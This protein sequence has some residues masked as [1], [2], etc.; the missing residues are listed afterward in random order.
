MAVIASP[1]SGSNTTPTPTSEANLDCAPQASASDEATGNGHGAGPRANFWG[2]A[3]GSIGVVFGDIG[4]SPLYA[5]QAA[6]GQAARDS[7]T[8]SSILGVVS[9]ALWALI[10]VVTVKYVLFVMRADNKGEGGVLSLMALAQRSLG[11][12]TTAIFFLGVI[13]AALFYGDAIITPAISVLGAFQG[14]NDVPAL[15]HI[16]TPHLITTVSF[17]I[18]IVVFSVQSRGTAS[19]AKL[20]G[21]VMVLWFIVLAVLGV[22]HLLDNPA[23]FWALSPHYAAMFMIKHGIVSFL[24]LGSVFLT[25]TGAEALYADM[26]HFGRWPIQASWLFFA[27]PCLALNY[28]GQGAYALKAMEFADAHHQAFVNQDWFFVMA[29]P[30]LR[31]PIVI[32]AV[33]A[34]IIASQAVITGAYSLSQQGVLLGLLPRM[35]VRRTSETQSGQIYLPQ[36]NSF[37]M[38]GVLALVAMFQS[39]DNLADAYGLAVTGTMLVTTILA[40]IVARRMWKWRLAA[41]LLLIV[42]LISLDSIFLAANALKIASG[43][44]APLLIGGALFVVMWT[45]VR[46]SQILTEKTR[47]EAVPL[48]DLTEMLRARPPHRVPGTAI[49]LTSDVEMAPVALMHNLKHNKVLHEKNLIATVRIAETPR[50]PESQRI[51]IVPINDVFK[52][53]VINYGF[54]ERPNLPKALALCRKHGLKFD[55]MATSFFLGRRSVVP[56]TQTA[57]P[58]WQDK[59]Y[60]YML[61]NSANPT[62]FFRIPPGRV[63]ELGAQIT[64]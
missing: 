54:M 31:A 47:R 26:G 57:M 24:V 49:F 55:I 60:I 14:M 51:E 61:K 29:P 1:V 28:L 5:F 20:F 19:V 46:G 21:P 36:I 16:I 3:V 44:W 52:Q 7:M 22:S 34:S 45:W 62:D 41:V 50:V 6:M 18:L 63:V 10:L 9:L 27:L 30:M 42:P 39:S 32:L 53:L 59:L 17:V 43:G 40:Y 64:V 4:T 48:A 11:K 15:K 13:G 23:V 37:L 58:M 33:C 56:A 35:D 2:L 38:F 25:V 12:R 8:R